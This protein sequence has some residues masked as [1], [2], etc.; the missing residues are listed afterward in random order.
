MTNTTQITPEQWG[1]AVKGGERPAM[2]RG[3]TRE[4]RIAYLQAAGYD[5]A[6]TRRRGRVIAGPSTSTESPKLQKA[7]SD[8]HKALNKLGRF[9][10]ES[11]VSKLGG[12]WLVTVNGDAVP[13][14]HKTKR[15]AIEMAGKVVGGLRLRLEILEDGETVE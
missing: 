3:L 12:E 4:E 9:G 13:L 6:G 11:F 14:L 10:A 2:P 15:E 7:R 1:Q 8:Y 5:N